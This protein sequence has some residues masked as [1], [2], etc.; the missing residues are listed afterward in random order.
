MRVGSGL[1]LGKLRLEP[2]LPV[3]LERIHLLLRAERLLHGKRPDVPGPL[4]RP[5]RLDDRDHGSLLALAFLSLHAGDELVG[6]GGA[7]A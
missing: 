3:Q 5:C 2:L 6:G 7:L 1:L 4:G